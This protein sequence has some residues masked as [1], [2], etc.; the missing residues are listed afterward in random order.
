MAVQLH[1]GELPH[2]HHKYYATYYKG[3]SEEDPR[4]AL[5][6]ARRLKIAGYPEHAKAVCYRFRKVK[7]AANAVAPSVAPVESEPVNV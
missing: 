1:N 5:E 6:C 4:E 2:I 3:M 7:V